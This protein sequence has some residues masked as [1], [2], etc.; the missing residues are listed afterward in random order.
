[1]SMRVLYLKRISII[2]LFCT[3]SFF[4]ATQLKNS[5]MDLLILNH[6]DQLLT[7]SIGNGSR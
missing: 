3:F 6:N 5:T 7:I 4:C 2:F 1:M